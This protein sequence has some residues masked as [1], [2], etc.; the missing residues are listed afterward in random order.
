MP[1]FLSPTSASRGPWH[2]PGLALL[3]V[4]RRPEPKTGSARRA[5]PGSRSE[6]EN[7]DDQAA[8]HGGPP[9]GPET[10]LDTNPSQLRYPPC[11]T[12]TV[13]S[14]VSASTADSASWAVRSGCSGVTDTKPSRTAW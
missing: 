5:S 8:T 6:G 9:P 11:P 12:S 14:N 7:S 4:E 2:A 3:R 10:R 13:F 1:R